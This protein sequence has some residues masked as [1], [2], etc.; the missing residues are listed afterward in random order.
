LGGVVA[1]ILVE[2]SQNVLNT[3][4]VK[5]PWADAMR[6]LGKPM[7][8]NPSALVVWILRGF[9]SASECSRRSG[10]GSDRGQRTR[11]KRVRGLASRRSSSVGRNGE[12]GHGPREPAR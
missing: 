9:V 11:R 4:V 1:G 8:I 7:V 5:Q 3:V 6:A 2:I 12:H 10:H